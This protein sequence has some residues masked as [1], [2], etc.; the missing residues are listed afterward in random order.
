MILV[1]GALGLAAPTAIAQ[2]QLGAAPKSG[3]EPGA[4]ATPDRPHR[5]DHPDHPHHPQED[6]TTATPEPTPQ[7]GVDGM[8]TPPSEPGGA[9]EPE[10]TP[11]PHAGAAPEP[12][13]EPGARATPDRPHRPYRPE[14]DTT[15]PTPERSPRAP[16]SPSQTTGNSG[17]PCVLTSAGLICPGN[18][19]CI[20][21]STGVSCAS[22]CVVTSAGISCPSGGEVAPGRPVSGPPKQT[23]RRSPASE[24][25]GERK[26]KTEGKVS[27]TA[28][29]RVEEPGGLL[30]FTGAPVVAWMVIGFALWAGG[31]LLRR[32][33]STAST[34]VEL[35][36]TAK[37]LAVLP[38]PSRHAPKPPSL[39]AIVLPSL[40]LVVSGVL[41]RLWRG[42]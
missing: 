36:T 41:L 7:A 4:R 21:T 23:R 1:A 35:S 40:A 31:L 30:P 6:T 28:V 29:A 27:P 2:S 3:A 9:V 26:A 12:G 18:P 37:P 13:A 25:K 17:A 10:Q 32:R 14:Q 11:E 38:G 24:V 15:A 39:W 20:L 5:P 33:P 22:G 8:P 34:T 19:D 42:R 16:A